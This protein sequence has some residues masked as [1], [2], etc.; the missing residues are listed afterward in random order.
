[1]PQVSLWNNSIVVFAL[2]GADAD[3][4]GSEGWEGSQEG[5]YLAE[6]VG[7]Q[8]FKVGEAEELSKFADGET[9]FEDVELKDLQRGGVFEE[10]IESDPALLAIGR[11]VYSNPDLLQLS[12]RRVGV[13]TREDLVQHRC[14]CTQLNFLDPLHVG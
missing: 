13:K 2:Q 8:E 10:E 5:R 4:D 9:T 3:F 6:V 12:S 7:R 1:M 11:T 14:R